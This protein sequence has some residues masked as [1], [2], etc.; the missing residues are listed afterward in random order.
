MNSY[1]EHLDESG[2]NV[3]SKEKN[4]WGKNEERGERLGD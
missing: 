3:K 2:Q 1:K 4:L